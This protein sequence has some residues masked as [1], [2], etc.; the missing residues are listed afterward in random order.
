MFRHKKIQSL[1]RKKVAEILLNYKTIENLIKKFLVVYY[2]TQNG[3]IT[4]LDLSELGWNVNVWKQPYSER[5]ED[6]NQI[7]G[8]SNLK[9]LK[10]LDLS[11]NRIKNIKLLVH[12]R[13]LTDLKIANNKLEDFKNLNYIKE[14]N[15]L[16][17]LDIR[18]NKIITK[19]DAKDFN[20]DL[21]ILIKDELYFQ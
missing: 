9:M 13:N 19:L 1:T 4:S 3:L 2:K 6:L 7:P 15:N 8:L 5:I 16:K 11:N 14:M 18:R 20:K 17:Y 12:L 21:K 10:S